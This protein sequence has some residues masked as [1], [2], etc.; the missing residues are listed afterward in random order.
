MDRKNSIAVIC[1]YFG[2]LPG[3]FG[4]WLLS[5]G[6]NPTID[7]LLFTDQNVSEKPDNVTVVNLEFSEVQ[8]LVNRR[9]GKAVNLKKPYKM[10]DLKPMYGV[11]FS[12]Y[13][14]VY[15]YWGYC[16]IDLVF[17]D[18]RRFLE[19]HNYREYDKFL[20][21]GHLTLLR[22]TAEINN[23]FKLPGSALGDWDYVITREQTL[24]FDEWHGIDEIYKKNGFSMFEARIFADISI[25]YHR[26]RLALDD[27]N[28]DHQVF[29]WEDGHVYRAFLDKGG[30]AEKEE[31]IYIHFKQRH[32]QRPTFEL[33]GCSSFFVG[34][35][36]Y[37]ERKARQFDKDTVERYNRY[38]GRAYERF[39]L[40]RFHMDALIGKIKNRMR[41]I[42]TR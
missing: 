28:Y 19:R 24:G 34:P 7:F 15:E 23:R 33:E 4:P 21:L 35:D 3:S 17:G 5:C 36:G 9:L 14:T 37:S 42:R 20:N 25:I 6:Y 8:S 16:D 31:F 32:F 2:K 39:E 40:M 12:E 30:Q 22:N 13:L 27:K 11:L 18:L 26:F 29:Y 38:R 1:A 10:C 41:A